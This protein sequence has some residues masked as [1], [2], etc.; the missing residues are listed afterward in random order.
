VVLH[1]PCNQESTSSAS[2]EKVGWLM[3]TYLPR[4]R[5]GSY[6]HARRRCSPP[7][8]H[9]LCNFALSLHANNLLSYHLHDFP[10]N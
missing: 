6:G 2:S 4:E 1:L 3:G 9:R 7:T 8:F 5:I 10:T